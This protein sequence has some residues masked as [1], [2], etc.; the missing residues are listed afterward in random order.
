MPFKS[1]GDAIQY[2]YGK[3]FSARKDCVVLLDWVSKRMWALVGPHKPYCKLPAHQEWFRV[4]AGGVV[5]EKGVSRK[6]VLYLLVNKFI[7][8]EDADRL[9]G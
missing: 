8:I 2:A 1:F 5:E 6:D 9:L 4:S 3:A 7:S